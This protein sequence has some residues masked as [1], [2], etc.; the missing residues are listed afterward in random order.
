LPC[1][2]SQARR[3][4][5]LAHPD[6][7]SAL[8]RRCGIAFAALQLSACSLFSF[9]HSAPPV[10]HP[11]GA[12]SIAPA[13]EFVYEPARAGRVSANRIENTAMT[14]IVTRF[15]INEAVRNDIAH[16]L[17]IAG[18]KVADSGKVLSGHIEV[19]AVDDVR[20]PAVWTLKVHYIV[21]DAATHRV[22]YAST[23]TV[24]QKNPKFTNVTIALDDTVKLSV[25]ALIR[26]PAF[27]R[28]VN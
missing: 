9:F 6:V 8:F 23:K 16:E 7:K 5:W 3:A 20:S 12:L 14:G 2:L 25:S 13:S 22:V 24:R 18:F 17:Q 15:D 21:H 10:E 1:A 11:T 19:F 28:S 26:D 4:A 27:V